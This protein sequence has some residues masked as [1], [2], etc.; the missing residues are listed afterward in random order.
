MSITT[1]GLYESV[2]QQDRPSGWWGLDTAGPTADDSG[3]GGTLTAVG[4]PADTATLLPAG[5]TGSATGCRDFNGSSGA[6]TAAATAFLD[7]A[8]TFTLELVMK[9]DIV[10]GT[11]TLLSKGTNGYQLRRN[12]TG[13]ELH[14]EG[15]GQIVATTG[16]TLAAGSTYHVVVAKNGSTSAKIWV[17]GIDRSGT[18]TDRTCADTATALN[19][20]RKSDASDWFDGKLDEVAVYPYPFTAD[21]AL[22]HYNAMNTGT[23]GQQLLGS[24][25]YPRFK[26]EVAWASPPTALYPLFQDVTSYLREVSTT[27]GRNFELDRIETGT[28]QFS[29]ANRNREFDDTYASSPFYP[30]VKPTRVVRF[31]AQIGSSQVYEIFYGYT[32]GHPLRRYG[33]G[34]DSAAEFTAADVY[35][36]LALDKIT[37][38]TV[39]SEEYTGARITAVLAAVSGL[40]SSVDTGQSLIVADD[41]NQANRLEHCLTVA[42]TEGG[43][44]YAKPSGIVRFEDRHN[45]VKNER[46]VRASYGQGSATYPAVVFEPQGDEARLFTAAAVTAPSGN[47]HT[48]VNTAAEAEHFKRT[49]ELTTLHAVENDAQSMAEAYANRYSTPRTRIPQLTVKPA[50]HTAPSTMWAQVLSHEIS[51]RIKSVE[52]PVGA[53]SEVQREHFIEGIRHQVT[54]SEWSVTFSV[55]PAELDSGFWLLGTGELDTASGLLNTVLGW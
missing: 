1:L 54:P 48:A 9:P 2:V 11:G 44:M 51:H 4:T 13:L 37:T 55:S 50:A 6:Y 18:V 42:E 25:T 29:L 28:M 23:F 40:R 24:N 45:R 12:T 38:E 52:I 49:K 5:E 3:N 31:R 27:R 43:V 41:L 32:E 7:L 16:L 26:M 14:K 15:S 35:K 10:T 47:I 46:T 36:A 20:A 8:D 30:N 22:T 17:N 53:A 33:N 39:R 21:M 19:I 34:R